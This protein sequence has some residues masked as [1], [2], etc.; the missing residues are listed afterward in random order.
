M[1]KE[2]TMQANGHTT[3][4]GTHIGIGRARDT[5]SWYQQLREWWTAY[6]AARHEAKLA[7]LNARWDTKREVVIPFRTDAAPE[8]AAAQGVFSTIGQLHG[9]A[10]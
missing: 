6:K 7:A 3:V 10:F 1:L 2:I 8:M 9:L 4:W 5:K